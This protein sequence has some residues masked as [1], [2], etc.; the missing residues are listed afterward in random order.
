MARLTIAGAAVAELAD[1]RALSGDE[2]GRRLAAQGVT[3]ARDPGTAISRALGSDP[4]FLQLEDGRWI[5]PALLLEGVTFLHVL[6][7]RET[8]LGILPLEPDLAP[9]ALLDHDD[10]VLSD[11]RRLACLHWDEDMAFDSV[12]ET[13]LIGPPGWLDFRAGS[14]LHVRLQTGRFSVAP[15]P[16]PVPASRLALRRVVE[17][18]RARLEAKTLAWLPS[19]VSLGRVLLEQLVDDPSLLE[20]P[21]APL[22]DAL[23]AAGLETHRD[24]VGLA[25]TDWAEWD[26]WFEDDPDE[27]DLDEDDFDDDDLDD[28]D[29]DDENDLDDPDDE[30]I[31]EALGLDA[32]ELDGLRIVLGAMELHQRIGGFDEPGALKNVARV[33]AIPA[34]ARILAVRAWQDPA[35][36][37]FIRDAV[38]DLDGPDSA[39]TRTVL[40]ASV[41]ARGD[42]LEAERLLRSAVAADPGFEPALIGLARFEE[43]RGDRAAALKLLRAAGVPMD[44][45]RRGLLE[46]LAVPAVDKVGRNDP[47][48]CG[49][50]RKYKACH[51]GREVLE[52][53]DVAGS[54]LRKLSV[55]VDQPPNRRLAAEIV[56]DAGIDPT[57]E[58]ASDPLAG[59]YEVLVRDIL[60]F[61]R[62]GVARFL[63]GRGVLLPEAEVALGRSWLDSRRVL[64]E[65]QAVHRGTGV[66][67][68]DMETDATI[69]L[70]DR[71]ISRSA[72]P[73]DVACLR[74]LPDGDGGVF[75]TDGIQVPRMHRPR[76]APMVA[77]GDGL[78]L[79][80]WLADMSSPIEVRTSEGELI[81]FIT[82][83]YRVSDPAAAARAL[84]RKLTAEEDGRFVE[85][86][87]RDGTPWIRGSITLD[88]D[89]ATV[90]ANSAERA[91][92]LVHTLLKAAPGARLLRREERSLDEA[93]EVARAAGTPPQEPLDP[94]DHPEL[95]A[96]LDSLMQGYEERWVDQSLPMLGGLT[97]RQ[98]VA[99]PARRADVEAFLD[100]V[101]WDQRDAKAGGMDAGRM[102]TLLGLPPGR[103]R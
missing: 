30:A 65:V 84:G 14:I 26:A 43:D 49:S 74:L 37:A 77:A 82:A 46:V 34:I 20:R 58:D 73:L 80:R 94:A 4:R 52:P 23:V 69:E 50:G 16:A 15:G 96:A 85:T 53:I 44:D 11:G 92:R 32:Y 63:D 68:R 101:A 90:E 88:G 95:A 5:V 7:A 64:Y 87:M 40:A 79:L 78:A 36:E 51:L 59:P 1:A 17:A 83:T 67:L 24:W 21:V 3:K 18:V 103:L 39:G 28:D 48:P 56:T 12:F 9:L 57:E 41:E 76:V 60:L 6:T 61:D 10:L 81:R 66:T 91:D 22:G 13:A 2:L 42:V 55:W 62:G 102:R 93:R 8:E 38:G 33:I 72:R 99:D 35:I 25:G 19:A 45:L 100:D 89:R 54:L 97:P 31:A 70:P 71:S 29:L 98:A 86:F 27:D 75:S 47:C